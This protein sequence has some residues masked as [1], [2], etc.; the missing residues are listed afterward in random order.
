[1]NNFSITLKTLKMILIEWKSA[2]GIYLAM[3]ALITTYLI[4]EDINYIMEFDERIHMSI[5]IPNLIF[6]FIIGI[7]GFAEEFR[8]V[9]SF[10]ISR[11]I[12]FFAQTLALFI[13][14][15]SLAIADSAFVTFLT[16]ASG[17]R[18]R[19]LLEFL[20]S[21]PSQAAEL[22]IMSASLNITLAFT[23][24]LIRLLYYRANKLQTILLSISPA[25]L[26]LFLVTSDNL[27]S[28]D[29]YRNL[30]NMLEWLHYQTGN[31]VNASIMML[32]ASLFF[33]SLCYILIRR[34]PIK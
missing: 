13:L 32:L 4:F 1:M 21:Q 15:T 26:Y 8:L 2:V 34:A 12:F 27:L 10:N 9:T 18:F 23:G 3:T 24:W 20:R 19:H 29:L 11:R 17:I 16:E 33:A 28:A 5:T 25:V 22:I 6:V 14:G 7:T 31:I 30:L